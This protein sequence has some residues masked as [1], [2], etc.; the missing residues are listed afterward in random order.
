VGEVEDQQLRDAVALVDA[1]P[2]GVALLHITGGILYVNPALQ[3]S[4]GWETAD[5]AGHNC[6]DYVHPDDL[7]VAAP[8]FWGGLSGE[9]TSPVELRLRTK[10]GGWRSAEASVGSLTTGPFVIVLFRD[11]QARNDQESAD[12]YER[13]L[14]SSIIRDLGVGIVALD[15]AGDL[16]TFNDVIEA[17]HRG[18]RAGVPIARWAA[19]IPLFDVLGS[20]LPEEQNPLFRIRHGER[21]RDIECVTISKDGATVHIRVSGGPVADGAGTALGAFAVMHDITEQRAAEDE[22]RRQATADPLT[23]LLNR[24]A[25][26]EYLAGAV[27][28]EGAAAPLSVLYLDLDNFKPVNDELGHRVGDLLLAA[29]AERIS[30][31][32]PGAAVARPGGDEFV[33]VTHTGQT[34][35]LVAQIRDTVER[36]ILIEGRLTTP[37]ISIGVAVHMAPGATP[38]QLIHAADSA[39]YHDK[40]LRRALAADRAA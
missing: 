8:V 7:A 31:A 6:F 24:A 21:L 10:D 33:V 35:A 39:M 38:A 34:D 13:Q 2:D 3:A 22:L 36:P 14:L 37:R 15:A 30:S 27:G 4:L 29:V 9:R 18:L 11:L 40:A 5:I 19:A 25:L 1:L 20:P 17:R 12:R 16:V 26:F 28:A 23:G 32:V